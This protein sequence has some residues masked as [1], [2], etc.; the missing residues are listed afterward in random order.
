MN[1]I[2][3][4]SSSVTSPDSGREIIVKNSKKVIFDKESG[5]RCEILKFPGHFDFDEVA[6]GLDLY[7]W[8]LWAYTGEGDQHE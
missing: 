5:T 8:D 3:W 7:G 4:L 1:M 2:K 6:E